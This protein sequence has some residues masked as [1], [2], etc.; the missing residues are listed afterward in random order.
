VK[1]AEQEIEAR[2]A[3]AMRRAE[4]PAHRQRSLVEEERLQYLGMEQE[5]LTQ[6]G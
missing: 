4:E 3:E 2:L 5:V 1:R 6:L